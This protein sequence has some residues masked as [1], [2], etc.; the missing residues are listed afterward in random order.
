MPRLAFVAATLICFCAA[1]KA[2]TATGSIVG[3]VRDPVSS[4]VPGAKSSELIRQAFS[5]ENF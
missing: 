4:V 1:A 3:T 5:P 2:Q